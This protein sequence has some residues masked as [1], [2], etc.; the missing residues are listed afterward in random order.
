MELMHDDVEAPIYMV[1]FDE[2]GREQLVHGITWRGKRFGYGA[3][4]SIPYLHSTRPISGLHEHN[5]RHL[6]EEEWAALDETN[7]TYG[8]HE[9]CH[10]DVPQDLYEA[11]EVPMSG[12]VVSAPGALP[13]PLEFDD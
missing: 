11:G 6:T 3:R 8:L 7:K 5:L 4:P 13:F 1:H 12:F 2:D 9:Q 10:P